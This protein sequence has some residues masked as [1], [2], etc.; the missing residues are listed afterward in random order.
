[1]SNAFTVQ[2]IYH[3]MDSPCTSDSSIFFLHVRFFLIIKI[4]TS[5]NVAFPFGNRQLFVR[6]L[7]KY[8]PF[9]SIVNWLSLASSMSLNATS[10]ASSLTNYLLS[11]SLLLHR[12]TIH[13]L[14]RGAHIKL[15]K[16]VWR[17]IFEWIQFNNCKFEYLIESNYELSCKQIHEGGESDGNVG[18]VSLYSAAG[19]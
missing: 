5:E 3:S 11:S 13:H 8:L 10:T 4:P 17:M 19:V 15:I 16:E 14:P 6:G 2:S 12:E 9:V 18:H 1:M 7:R